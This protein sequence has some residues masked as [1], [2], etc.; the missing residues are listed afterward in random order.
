MSEA[1]PRSALLP[2][3]E[4]DE[5]ASV[6]VEARATEVRIP[7]SLVLAA[8]VSWRLLVVGAA[9][10]LTVTVLARIQVIVVPAAVALLLAC[11]LWPVARW[12]RA[13]GASPLVAAAATL[14]GLLGSLAVVLV[15]LA[16]RAAE[17]ISQLDVNVFEGLDVVKGW[18]IQGPLH[19]S[20]QRVDAFFGEL[21]TQLRAASGAIAS[22]ALGGAM[23]A[24]EIVV[25]ILLALVLLFFFLKDGDR[26][27]LW[28]RGFLPLE[29]QARW[30][31]T[32]V[33]VRDVLASFIR[34]TT[35]IAFVDA[36]GIGIGL[37]LLGI[38]LV[39]PLAVL[40]FIGGF[41]PIVGATVAGFV[42][43]MVALVSGGL[44]KALAVLGVVVAVQ[45]LESHFLQPVV[46]GRSVRLHPAAVLLAVGAG[47]VLYGVAGA[48]LAV[49]I[50]AALSVVLG[51]HR[52][53]PEV[54]VVL[55]GRESER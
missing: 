45:Q 12:L 10:Y 8:A 15:L 53:R 52:A 6:R 4:T 18:L 46:V 38:P 5:D 49:P 23:L 2:G 7:R 40:T 50:T 33:E 36:A 19:L 55:A 24:L 39:L 25:G 31:A 16:P 51:R 21:E 48:L 30:H 32:A 22:G 11:A 47:G 28:V 43:T 29:R 17:E 41:V 1:P 34:G 20:E 44:L 26:M 37:Y 27:W 13:R 35:V 3:E 9:V 54:E 14:L 42:A